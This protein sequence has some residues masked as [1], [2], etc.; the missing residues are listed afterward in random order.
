MSSVCSDCG[1]SFEDEGATEYA[2]PLCPECFEDAMAEVQGM[3]SDADCESSLN[4]FEFV[5]IE[6]GETHTNI[7]PKAVGDPSMCVDCYDLSL[8]LEK[9]TNELDLTDFKPGEEYL[10]DVVRSDEDDWAEEEPSYCLECH[11]LMD[12][13]DARI[14]SICS[15]CSYLSEE[16]EQY[17]SVEFQF[18]YM[19][20]LV[21]D[22]PFYISNGQALCPGQLGTVEY[23]PDSDFMSDLTWE[24]TLE[25]KDQILLL[26]ALVFA[27]LIIRKL[28]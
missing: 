27:F 10:G 26:F 21:C 24:E 14:S 15:A 17:G 25:L 11:E 4:S 16:D 3:Y 12:N 6:C 9:I 7:A 1:R 20:I 28:L 8:S 22:Q 18:K 13:D 23:M 2:E 5:C 19:N